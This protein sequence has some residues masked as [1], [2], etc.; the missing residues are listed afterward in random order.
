LRSIILS[1]T[2][3]VVALPVWAGSAPKKEKSASTKKATVQKQASGAKTEAKQ[4]DLSPRFDLD[5]APSAD[6]PV[7]QKKY[8][9]GSFGM[10]DP[11]RS[12]VSGTFRPRLTELVDLHTV[13]LVGV[14]WEDDEYVGIVQD[15]QG[16]GYALRPGDRV[17]S[18]TVV[19]ITKETLVA[20]MSLFGNTSRVT[21]RLHREVKE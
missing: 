7:R 4:E 12:L 10:R 19:S 9:Y 15:A 13:Q 21:L 1:L 3:L 5:A 6:G 8:F 17:R 16:Y 14:L 2:I 20:R 18:G 11:F